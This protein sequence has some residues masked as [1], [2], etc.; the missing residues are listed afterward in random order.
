M[1]AGR[2][3]IHS[4]ENI[5]PEMGDEAAFNFFTRVFA[6][7]FYNSYST[8]YPSRVYLKLQPLSAPQRRDNRD[9]PATRRRGL[10][11]SAAFNALGNDSDEDF[12]LLD[13]Y[14]NFIYWRR[15]GRLRVSPGISPRL[16]GLPH[17]T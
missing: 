10:K 13:V 12:L 7:Q 17:A 3:A 14:V 8:L 9:F 15:G 4:C 11:R 1:I 6:L 5:C 16:H 2:G